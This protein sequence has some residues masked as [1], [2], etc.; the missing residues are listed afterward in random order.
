MTNT[1]MIVT[2]Y[3]NGE[4]FKFE[5][6]VAVEQEVTIETEDI[7]TVLVCSL[8]GE[9]E[10]K[11]GYLKTKS[12]WNGDS[13]ILFSAPYLLEHMNKCTNEKGIFYK[14]GAAHFAALIDCK[15][16]LC[17]YEDI[18]RRCAIYKAIGFSVL[19]NINLDKCALLVSCRISA[20]IIKQMQHAGI[21]TIISRSAPT[22]KAIYFARENFMNLYGFARGEI[23]NIYASKEV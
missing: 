20:D 22:D 9:E 7:K 5:D 23:I 21:R 16:R 1:K 3:N 14:T 17:F 19:H 10:L 12:N 8:G 2:R 18:S 15:E 6:F 4:M 11:A 13:D